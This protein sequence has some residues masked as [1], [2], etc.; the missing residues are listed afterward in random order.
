MFGALCGAI[1]FAKRHGFSSKITVNTVIPSF[2]IFHG[3]GRI[4]C[5][6]SGCCYGLVLS[7]NV[8]VLG[9]AIHHFPVQLVEAVFE[10]VMFWLLYKVVK[11]E[12]RIQVYLVAYAVFRF[13][14]E[15]FRGDEVRGFVLGLST[16]QWISILILLIMAVG[17]AKKH[18][19]K[20]ELSV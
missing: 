3:F 5:F 12:K 1:I 16:S 13:I 7:E 15:Y 11:F 6:L 19:A 18:C 20:N 9:A 14:A 2:V 10:F 8:N 4:G 17:L